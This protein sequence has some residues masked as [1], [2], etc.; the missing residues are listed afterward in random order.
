M[1]AGRQIAQDESPII[2][3]SRNSQG[4]SPIL[5]LRDRRM[6]MSSLAAAIYAQLLCLHRQHNPTLFQTWA[7]DEENTQK[8][9]ACFPAGLSL[10]L[11]SHSSLEANRDAKPL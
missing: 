2:H 6:P 5:H 7:S 9:R 1:L 8:Y 10:V 11:C 3:K 4:M